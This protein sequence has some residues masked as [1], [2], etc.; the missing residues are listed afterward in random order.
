MLNM[1]KGLALVLAAATAFTF[2]PVANLGA[3]VSA[4]AENT[5][6]TLDCTGTKT[7]DGYLT[8][9]AGTYVIT[10][11]VK[12]N[13]G[14]KVTGLT[15][16]NG[17]TYSDDNKVAAGTIATKAQTKLTFDASSATANGTETLKVWKVSQSQM[18]S[19]K[20]TDATKVPVGE[21]KVEVKNWSNGFKAPI[22]TVTKSDGKTT[23]IADKDQYG[24]ESYSVAQ[25]SY[26]D[27]TVADTNSK[28]ITDDYYLDVTSKTGSVTVSYLGADGKATTSDKAAKVRLTGSIVGTDTIT[29]A[30]KAVKAIDKAS[31]TAAVAKDGVIA[32]TTLTVKVTD[33]TSNISAFQ[34]EGSDGK[35]NYYD[36]SYVPASIKSDSTKYTTGSTLNLDTQITK[37]KQLNVVAAGALTFLSADPSIVSVDSTGK[38]TANKA[39]FTTITVQAAP[40]AKFS[41]E[42]KTVN[43]TVSQV[44][45]DVITA[46]V[47]GSDVNDSD[48]AVNLDLSTA[49]ATNAVKS[50]K[51][52]AA[53]AANFKLSYVLYSDA[54]C[55]SVVTANSNDIATLSADGTITAGAKEGTV[56]VKISTATKGDIA[57]NYKIV[58]VV[59]NKLPEAVIALDDVNLDLKDNKTVTLAPTSNI[60]NAVFSYALDDDA[61]RAAVLVGNKLTATKVGAGKLTVTEP[62][63]ATTRTTK[64]T[65]NVTVSNEIQKKASDLKVTSAKTVA[66]TKGA[67]S[68]ITYTVATGSA[69]SFESSDPTVATVSGSSIQAL[70]AGTA[71]ITVKTPETDKTLAGSDFV[72]V[73]VTEAA[74]KP[75]KVTG[76]K[77]AN[78]KGAAVSVSWKS[79]GANVLYRVYKKVGN[80]SW[81][82]KNVAGNKTTLSVKKGAKVTVKVKAYVKDANGK[83]TWGPTATKKTFKTDKK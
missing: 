4:Y 40:T 16:I 50:A 44:A 68:Q 71:I 10:S 25:G 83:T 2:A 43:V 59:V 22:V 8:L 55:T 26:I 81:K 34:W 23:Y 31:S 61:A 20:F 6:I 5:Q 27:L 60:A 47:N 75:A 82:A 33:N 28:K 21:F 39:G 24:N 35:T 36:D 18:T 14:V 19:D 57:G 1:K 80:G 17:L 15:E 11:D 63:T 78:K 48:K 72:V 79:Q 13:L 56:Y 42:T 53:S 64:K 58:K 3:S 46:K 29:V 67:S 65:V 45:T 66:L 77:V 30:E 7:A 62:A 12:D 9:D 74:V 51:I 54:A 49:T 69:V 37:A 73:T 41:T 52:D 38:V 70:K 32:S 76:V